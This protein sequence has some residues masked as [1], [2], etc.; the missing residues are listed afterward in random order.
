MPGDEAQK[1]ANLRVLLG[2]QWTHPGTHILFMGGEIGQSTEWSHDLGV[3]WE[4]LQYDYH[5]G[6]QNW[7]KA[8]NKVYQDKPALWRNAFH[9]DGF[10]WISGGDT[11]N[12][13]LV[14]VR[15][16]DPGDPMLLVVCHFNLNHI[17]AYSVGVPH[18]GIWREI[19]NS[20]AKEFGGSGI[21]IGDLKAVK[22]AEHGK[23][24]SVTFPLV[25]LS[26]MIFE[27]EVQKREKKLP[28]KKPVAKKGINP[29]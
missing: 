2:H 8:L 17:P 22:K 26:I 14:F 16:G 4:L 18:G 13:V 3:P 9:P 7:V 10:E 27:G 19:L 12:S 29:K 15:H 28:E 1:F 6:I 24:Y 21:S 5:R 25:P 11:E 23:D 20:D